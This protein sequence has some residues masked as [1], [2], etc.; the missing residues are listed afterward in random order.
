MN[1]RVDL[2]VARIRKLAGDGEFLS[3]VHEVYDWLEEEI[4]AHQPVCRRRGDCCRFVEFGHKL[5]VTSVELAFLLGTCD[6]E[7]A[8]GGMAG[9]CPYLIGDRCR[10]RQSRPTGCRIFFCESSGQGW[11]EDLTEST[12]AR[13]RDLHKRFDV[14]YAYVEWLS[15][16]RRIIG[17]YWPKAS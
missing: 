2:P 15:A 1:D 12:L 9:T 4:A 17:R 6:R 16:L 5:Y 7:S 10:A 8:T 13:L 3:V 11:Q 14:P